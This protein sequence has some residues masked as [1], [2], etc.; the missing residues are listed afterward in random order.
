MSNDDTTKQLPTEDKLDS[1]ITL[2]HHLT[3]SVKN[4]DS[5]LESVESRL[6]LLEQKVDAR[7]HETRPV[8]ES[9]QAQLK[10][11]SMRLD[12]IDTR[13]DKIEGTALTT[14]FELRELR[15]ELKEHLPA[16]K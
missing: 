15:K 1:L 10:E 13:L 14:Q 5:R 6:D 12:D 4:I 3:D 8:W 11:M 2:V 9:V 16:L 7:L